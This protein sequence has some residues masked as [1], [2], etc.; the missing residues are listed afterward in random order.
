MKTLLL[1]LSLI[2]SVSAFAQYNSD[3]GPRYNSDP[4][5]P[6]YD[7]RGI[8][9]DNQRNRHQYDNRDYRQYRYER[10]PKV[11]CKTWYDSYGHSHQ[12]CY[13]K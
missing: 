9:R 3:T 12:K 1:V 6:Y 8:E 11:K 4:E 13:R 2:V 10:Q 5:R 7:Y